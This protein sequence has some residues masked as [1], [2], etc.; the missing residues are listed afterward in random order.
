MAV[1]VLWVA[2]KVGGL[3]PLGAMLA[4]ELLGVGDGPTVEFPSPCRFS[5]T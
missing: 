1:P 2:L 4:R 5:V 3:L